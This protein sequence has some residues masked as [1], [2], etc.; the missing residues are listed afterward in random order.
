[1]NLYQL[2]ETDLGPLAPQ[3]APFIHAWSPYPEDKNDVNPEG[4]PYQID[5]HCSLKGIVALADT[6]C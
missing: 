6:V 3:L 2:R 1:M 4:R 5:G